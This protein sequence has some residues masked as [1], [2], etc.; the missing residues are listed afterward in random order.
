MEKNTPVLSIILPVY[1]V[2]AY[3]PVCL[4]SILAQTFEN[5]EVL[6]VDDG[7]KDGSGRILDEYATR[8]ERIRVFHKENGGLSDA[9]NFGIEAARGEYFSF[10]DSDDYVEPDMIELL[11]SSLRENRADMAI[12]SIIKEDEP[13]RKTPAQEKEILLEEEVLSRGEALHKLIERNGWR[14]VTVCNKLYKKELF[15]E[16][17]FP[18]GKLHEDEFTVHE[19]MGRCETI[20]CVKEPLYHYIQRAES[21]THAP[22]SS[23]RLDAAEAFF[24]RSDFCL[25]RGFDEVG[26][27]SLVQGGSVL[28]RY[29]NN[30]RQGEAKRRFR[31]LKKQFNALYK[32]AIRK[33]DLK[34]K[35]RLTL[36]F[37]S[38]KLYNV[39][40]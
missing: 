32:K 20:S 22:F 35:I 26:V 15:R 16:V 31:E 5:F 18:F 37:V 10:I 30:C 23:K 4:D 33:G 25:A 27:W 29:Y 38:P 21:I 34:K 1:N 7:S 2:E 9:R 6:A 39:L 36:I 11:L 8:D 19:L 40:K 12:C 13:G 28:A 24:C 14:Y 17:R 3:L